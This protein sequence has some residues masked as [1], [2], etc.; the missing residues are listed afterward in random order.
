MFGLVNGNKDKYTPGGEIQRDR[1]KR[2]RITIGILAFVALVVINI[3][4][5]LMIKV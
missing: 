2:Q 5:Y 1:M 4:F 3:I